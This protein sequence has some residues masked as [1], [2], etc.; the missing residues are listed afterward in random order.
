[1]KASARMKE[2][3]RLREL[4]KASEQKA[5]PDAAMESLTLADAILQLV[6][7]DRVEAKKA[8]LKVKPD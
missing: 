2:L 7:E 1:M 3:H 5:T 4:L 6:D 8:V